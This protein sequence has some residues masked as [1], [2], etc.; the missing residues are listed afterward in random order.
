MSI[1]LTESEASALRAWVSDVATDELELSEATT[2]EYN[3]LSI[4]ST[5][6]DW[7]EF[8]QMAIDWQDAIFE[9]ITD[10]Q[11]QSREWYVRSWIIRM[12]REDLGFGWENGDPTTEPFT[13]TLRPG[14][15]RLLLDAVEPALE[16]HW[17]SR[18]H[19][20][21]GDEKKHSSVFELTDRMAH[22]K[23]VLELRAFTDESGGGTVSDFQLSNILTVCEG[24]AEVTVETL[25]DES[26][27]L[28][29]T[30]KHL[31]N[32]LRRIGF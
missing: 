7:C 30:E 20:E 1:E 32:V 6:T 22:I 10:D 13:L 17:D 19:W 25:L 24:H 5:G 18:A 2:V 31:L 8:L 23:D 15:W 27:H 29:V 11:D 21:D 14:E 9:G 16:N 26:E 28:E 4:T 3:G 12:V